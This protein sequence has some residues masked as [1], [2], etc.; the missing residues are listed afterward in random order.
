VTAEGMEEAPESKQRRLRLFS[1]ASNAPRARRPTDAVLVALT[2]LGVAVLSIPA[3]G[4]TAT[5]VAVTSLIKQLPGLFGWFWELSFNL[6]IGWSLL[7]LVVSLIGRGRRRLFLEE[8][9]AAGVALGLALLAGKVAGTDWSTSLGALPSSGPPAVYLAVRLTLATAVVVTASPHMSRPVRTVGR[10]ILTLGALSGI[11]LGVT[12][13]IGMAAG[14][15]VG[16]ASGAIVHLLLGSPAGRLTLEQIAGALAEIGVPVSQ[17]RQAPLEPRGVALA[18]ATTKDGR[19]LLVK[20]YGR[21]AHEGQFLISLWNALWFRGETPRLATGRLEQVEHEAFVSL[22][23]ERGGVPVEPIVAAG[24]AVERDA[25]LVT[26]VDGDPLG[27]IDAGDVDDEML[28]GLWQAVIRLGELGVS[29][30]QIDWHRLVIRPDGTS[31]IADLSRAKI[32]ATPNAVMSDRAQLLVA[33]ALAAGHERAVAAAAASLGREGLIEMLPLLQPAVLDRATRHAIKERDWTLD[34]VR[35]RAADAAGVEPPDLEKLRRVSVKSVLVVALTAVFAYAL[36][37]QL[38]GVDV[39]QVVDELRSADM[40]WL[41]VALLAAPVAQV[42]QAFSTMG[43]S[44]QPIV[45]GPVLMLQY[46]VQFIQL[47]VPSSAAR[48][49]LEIRFFQRVGIDAGGATSIGLIDSLSGFALQ[50]LLIVTIMVFGL[51]SIDTSVRSSS[52]SSSGSSGGPELWVLLLLLLALGA[53][54][55]SV[56][57]KYRA[58]IRQA[59]PEYRARIREQLASG[60]TAMRVL[61]QPKSLGMLFGGNLAAQVVL[62][63][64]LGLCLKA[65]GYTTS[66]AGLI[67]VN[68]FVSVFA[69]FMPVPGGMGVAE[70]G[71]TAGLQALGIPSAAAMSTAIAFRLV[72]FYLPPIWG[73]VAMRW[74]RRHSYI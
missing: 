69:G 40:V 74:L 22:L 2:A 28:R 41:V 47:A 42:F 71:Y 30:G 32:A 72:T 33:T 45:F 50:V 49:A 65:F 59:I 68:T 8:L 27:S 73:S 9:L 11:A 51:V 1:S 62:A 3:P 34:D 56:V 60:K 70:A 20:V 6:L 31:A 46:A 35:Q 12:L 16:V 17:V 39:S 4:P 63:I 18:V 57:P 38:A 37:A 52:G 26:A 21:D 67:L 53:T 64:I 23:A 36:I 10:G 44:I 43:A 29:H 66:L 7:L 5:D 15:L 13:P 19:S 25:L 58:A 55:A 61:R 54:V 48:I 24:M 14:F